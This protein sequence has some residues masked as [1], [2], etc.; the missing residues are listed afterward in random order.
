M[1]VAEI[2]WGK[3]HRLRWWCRAEAWETI[4]INLV[5]K[6]EPQGEME[7]PEK[8]KKNQETE[9]KGIDSCKKKGEEDQW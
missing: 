6:D 4:F 1:R 3:G 2:M 5:E 9:V 8:W 7:K